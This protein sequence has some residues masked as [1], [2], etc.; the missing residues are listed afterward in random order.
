MF[1][2]AITEKNGAVRYWS[3]GDMW[4]EHAAEAA[5]FVQEVGASMTIPILEN[6]DSSMPT[7]RVVHL[8]EGA[9]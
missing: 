4:S 8:A 9:D 1:L 3:G 5:R 2:I 6:A 7:A